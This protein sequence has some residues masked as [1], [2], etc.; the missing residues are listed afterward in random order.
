MLVFDAALGLLCALGTLFL[1]TQVGLAVSL[2]KMKENPDPVSFQD[3]QDLPDGV[4]K[5]VFRADGTKL[6]TW[7]K[8][9][10]PP[11][12]LIPGL[13]HTVHSMN[14]LW[15]RLSQAGFRVITFDLRGHGQSEAGKGPLSLQHLLEDLRAVLNSYEV[16]QALLVGHGTGAYLCARYLL[17]Y[18]EEASLRVRG[19]VSMAGFAGPPAEGAPELRFGQRLLRYALFPRL[20][21]YSFFGKG[22]A[23]Q[24]FGHTPAPAKVKARWQ[25]LS[26]GPLQ[27]LL[28]LYAE[29][30]TNPEFYEALSEIEVP[31]KIIA[32]GHDHQ[33]SPKHAFRLAHH[34]PK[35][36]L[37]WI[38]QAG[39]FLP[40][41]A[42]QEVFELIK[43]LDRNSRK[44]ATS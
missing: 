28:P 10:G 8:A 38:E 18:P 24:G 43:Q 37:H 34:L 35:A 30:N 26:H 7:H 25:M 21:R 5:A 40:W 36:Q 15:Q 32:G 2:F 4:E 23:T 9:S 39:N 20:L 31:W 3:L 17:T 13:G 19:V 22:I 27:K 33:T 41:E 11:V 44:T 14:L 16:K 29:L 42:P 6:Q 1:M 12:V